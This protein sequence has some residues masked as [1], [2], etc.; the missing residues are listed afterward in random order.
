[1]G[2]AFQQ[3]GYAETGVIQSGEGGQKS[4]WQWVLSPG[5]RYNRIEEK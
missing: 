1:M 5:R 2:W 4:N 3:L